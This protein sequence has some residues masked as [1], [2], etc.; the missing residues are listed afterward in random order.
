M[1]QKNAP[2][3]KP[4][5]RRFAT[6]LVAVVVIGAAALGYA[7][8]QPKATARV[9]DP[10][11]PLPKP[12]GHVIGSDSAPV[13][14]TMFG[15]FECPT[16]AQFVA[17]T[18]P[19]VRSRLVNTGLARFRFL[20]FPLSVHKNTLFAHN[21]AACAG[22]QGKFWEMHDALYYHQP[23]W[24]DLVGGKDSGHP[25]R[26]MAGYAKGLGI[27]M[28]KYDACMDSEPYALQIRAN[29]QE[30]ER[31]GVSGTPTLIIGRHMLPPGAPP[32]DMIKAYVDTATAEAN[33]AKAAASKTGGKK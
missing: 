25:A 9:I 10:N 24:S 7:V 21:A 31:L 2:R 15:D 19:D 17:I 27:D 20:D 13:E 33:A 32:Y 22:A 6:A 28:D 30:G 14:I 1:A 23:E 11:T 18:E 5:N 12:L 4:Q 26:S 8:S 29:E 16:C 3:P